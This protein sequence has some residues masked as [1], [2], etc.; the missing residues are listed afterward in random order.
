MFT[1]KD[2]DTLVT[3]LSHF[4]RVVAT[5]NILTEVSN[6]TGLL[7]EPARR[8]CFQSL[9]TTIGTLDERYVTSADASADGAFLH[10]GLTDASICRLARAPLP[11]LTTDFDL[12]RHLIE[13]EIDA[14]NFNHIRMWGW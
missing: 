6:L 7:D 12:W 2:F 13:Q 14:L 1:N 4:S 9:K 3:V 11:V 10:L 8:Q 5:P